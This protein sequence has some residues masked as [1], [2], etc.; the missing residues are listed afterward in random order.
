M[1]AVD[2]LRFGFRPARTTRAFLLALVIS[3]A[4]VLTAGAQAARAA[5]VTW[6]CG[7]IAVGTACYGPVGNYYE[8]AVQYLGADT[9][10]AAI[11]VNVNTA[12]FYAAGYGATG[13][14]GGI[15]VFLQLG[16]VHSYTPYVVNQGPNSHTVYGYAWY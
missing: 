5:Y 13:D 7:V 10:T 12:G 14:Y 11:N 9:I 16:Q 15:A 1:E 4:V 8:T 2:D 6:N 3:F